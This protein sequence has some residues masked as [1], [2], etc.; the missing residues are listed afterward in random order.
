MGEKPASRGRKP[1]AISKREAAR[2]PHFARRLRELREAKGLSFREL[3]RATQGAYSDQT[4]SN[5]E[6]GTHDV[7]LSALP[8]VAAALGVSPRE[9]ID[10]K[11]LA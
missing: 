8:I 4:F 10:P 2:L 3:E 11:L 9:L 5:W 6:Q 7:P 1:K